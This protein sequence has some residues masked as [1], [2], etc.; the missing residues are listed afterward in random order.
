MKIQ[1]LENIMAW[2]KAR[3]LTK[4]ICFLT[5]RAASALLILLAWNVG[6]GTRNAFAAFN[7]D[8]VGT[9]GAGFLKLG[10]DARAAGMGEAFL[11]VSE[12]AS[13]VSYNP[14]GLAALD[15]LSLQFS[16]TFFLANINYQFIGYA[17]PLSAVFQ[18][19]LVSG[20]RLP[21]KTLPPDWGVLGLGLLYLN[22]GS[23]PRIDN[24]GA[25]GGSF[26]PQD[27]AFSASY[28]RSLGAFDL[29]ATL[30]YLSLHIDDSA[31]AVAG[32]L[33][34]RYRTAWQDHPWVFAAAVKNVGQNVKFLNQQDPLP[35]SFSLGTS[36]RASD[37]LLLAADG[38]LPNDNNPYF[39]A[40]AELKQDFRQGF[41]TFLRIGYQSLDSSSGLG[42][43]AG[44]SAGAGVTFSHVRIDYA[45]VPFGILGNTHRFGLSLRF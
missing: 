23:I 14:A 2:Q 27:L 5:K 13:A 42:G 22:A 15:A 30:K 1:K 38:I 25:G 41:T 37:A 12:E 19:P 31:T 20:E 29:G 18:E 8:A 7:G 4:R 11:A 9:S 44:F 10:P 28:A 32:D 3:G 36:F 34:L 40:G 35:L 16:Q 33:G 45:W 43:F 6:L 17:Q 26:T 21:A 39:A 24:T